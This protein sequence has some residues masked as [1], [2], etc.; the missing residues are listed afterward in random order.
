MINFFKKNKNKKIESISFSKKETLV[1]NTIIKLLI[2][3]WE[4]DNA[5]K[6]LI[7]D[8]NLSKKEQKEFINK[9]NLSND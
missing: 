5:V 2:K 4:D 1:L 6:K 9:I 3:S 8:S 7:K